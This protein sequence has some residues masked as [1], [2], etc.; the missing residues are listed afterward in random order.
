MPSLGGGKRIVDV[1]VWGIIFLI[2]LVILFVRAPGVS[3]S[4]GSQQTAS[5]LNT[6]GSVFDSA[7]STLQGGK[8]T[9]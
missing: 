6:L 9:A 2:G 3:G 7:V 8:K 4:S 1:I 5:I